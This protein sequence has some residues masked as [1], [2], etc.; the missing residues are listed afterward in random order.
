MNELLTRLEARIAEHEAALEHCLEHPAQVVAHSQALQELY[1][2]RQLTLDTLA[3]RAS[4]GFVA[5]P[6]RVTVSP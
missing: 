4:Y 5:R 2:A 6:Q 3:A 1:A